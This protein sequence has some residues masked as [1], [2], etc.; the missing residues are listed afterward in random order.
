MALTLG[1]G[2]GG[3][4]RAAATTLVLVC[5]T[6]GCR[7]AITDLPPPPVRK[8]AADLSGIWDASLEI[9]LDEVGSESGGD[10][11]CLG[12]G[13]ITLRNIDGVATHDN[14]T[15]SVP[16]CGPVLAEPLT[17]TR[18]AVVEAEYLF[19]LS[20]AEVRFDLEFT[21]SVRVLSGGDLITAV[22]T[23]EQGEPLAIEGRLYEPWAATLRLG[24]RR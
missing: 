11:F 24:R 7:G 9:L 2:G 8:S 15:L 5:G 22:M 6:L 20:H 12:Q 3:K 17:V 13:Q 21:G 10:V 18:A 1:S 19:T 14:S 23:A 16:R 4:V